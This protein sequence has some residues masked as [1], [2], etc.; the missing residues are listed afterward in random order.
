VP[1]TVS[2]HDDH[3]DPPG[4]CILAIVPPISAFVAAGFEAGTQR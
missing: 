1:A 3:V 2:A 4:V